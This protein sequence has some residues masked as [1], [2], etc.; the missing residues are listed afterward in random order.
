MKKSTL[1]SVLSVLF[2]LATVMFLSLSWNSAEKKYESS[3]T[4]PGFIEK[5]SD[6]ASIKSQA[7]KLVSGLE[8]NAEL[9]VKVPTAKLNKENPFTPAE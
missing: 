4:I 9:P 5:A 6:V 2:L 3:R 7:E 1:N 8:N